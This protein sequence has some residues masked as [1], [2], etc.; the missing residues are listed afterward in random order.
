MFN[1]DPLLVLCFMKYFAVYIHSLVNKTCN[2]LHITDSYLLL[3][4]CTKSQLISKANC[5]A[6]Y[7]SKKEQINSFLL[8]CDVFSCFF[9]KK[10][11]TPKR[12]FEIIWPLTSTISGG[13]IDIIGEKTGG[14][15]ETETF[16]DY[17]SENLLISVVLHNNNTNILHISVSFFGSY[18]FSTCSTTSTETAHWEFCSKLIQI[19][20][21]IGCMQFWQQIVFKPLN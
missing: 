9:W 21:M 7:S 4:L 5:Q 20:L 12:H 11:K 10:L 16:V 6:V 18:F 19:D 1:S 2:S 14:K 17:F 8:L 3:L 13:K 15:Q